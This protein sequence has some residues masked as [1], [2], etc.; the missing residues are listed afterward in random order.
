MSSIPIHIKFDILLLNVHH[1]AVADLRQIR[2]RSARAFGCLVALIQQ[3]RADPVLQA[4]LHDV[5]VDG[6]DRSGA[7]GVKPWYSVQAV[8]GRKPVY[9]L[10]A[11]DLERQG[12]R[13]RLI[14][15][16]HWRDQSFNILAVVARAEFDYDDP[17]HPIRQR[18]LATI[19]RDFADA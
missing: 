9:R 15:L 1:D 8:T 3:L 12:L 10:R 16:F 7:V 4:R 14:Y 13:Y 6:N 18:I 5:D 19:R 2:Q 11:W 17:E